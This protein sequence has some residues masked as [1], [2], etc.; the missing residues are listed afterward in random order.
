MNNAYLLSGNYQT[1]TF[2]DR[3]KD[4]GFGMATVSGASIAIR[5]V[6]IPDEKAELLNKAQKEVDEIKNKFGKRIYYPQVHKILNRP[7]NL[8]LLEVA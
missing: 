5:D 3:L 2:L 1:V 7:H 8:K 6:L 4:L